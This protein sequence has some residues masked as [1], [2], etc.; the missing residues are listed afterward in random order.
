MSDKKE[1]NTQVQSRRQLLKATVAGT[2]AVVAGKSLPEQ[3]SRPLVDSVTL[4]AHAETSARAVGAPLLLSLAA[5][6]DTLID[7]L[8][9]TAHAQ[10]ESMATSNLCFNLNDNGTIGVRALVEFT[11]SCVEEVAYFTGTVSAGTEQGLQLQNGECAFE[12][13]AMVDVTMSG[14]TAS[15][16]F[17]CTFDGAEFSS[18]FNISNPGCPIITA[19]IPNE[20]SQGCA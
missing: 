14:G 13:E 12:V 6:D 7:N 20:C 4:P 5:A 3:W 11:E 1:Q 17:T 10:Q 15:G 2:G 19:E 9:P 8:I 16:D 18:P